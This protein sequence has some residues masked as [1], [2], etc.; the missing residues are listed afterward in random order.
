M[1]FAMLGEGKTSSIS[2]WRKDANG[3]ELR[4]DYAAKS[5]GTIKTR[6]YDMFQ[7]DA[8]LKKIANLDQRHSLAKYMDSHT[9]NQIAYHFALTDTIKKPLPVTVIVKTKEG[10][11][12]LLSG[13]IKG[14]CPLLRT[15]THSGDVKKLAEM[16][17]V[18]RPYLHY[19]GPQLKTLSPPVQNAIYGYL[20]TLGVS[21]EVW[22]C[23]EHS[24]LD[25][26]LKTRARQIDAVMRFIVS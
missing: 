4:I 21:R 1:G 13:D 12:L 9:P 3:T 10:T 2:L 26:T 25:R 20:A 17:K 5:F 8:L 15:A 22:Q 16:N 14:G 19:P 6:Y 7:V 24:A 11:G 23:I 18:D